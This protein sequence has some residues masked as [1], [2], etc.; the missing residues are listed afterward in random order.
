MASQDLSRMVGTPALAF[1]G[2]PVGTTGP[3]ARPAPIYPAPKSRANT[4]GAKRVSGSS[5]DYWARLTFTFG[6]FT[7]FFSVVTFGSV[8]VSLTV[9]VSTIGPWMVSVLV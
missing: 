9:P 4:M 7:S 8:M 2:G 3:G 5:G 6:R 1:D